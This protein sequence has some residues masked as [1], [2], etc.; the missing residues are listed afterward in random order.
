M[1]VDWIFYGLIILGL[2]TVPNEITF[3]A[4]PATKRA[5]WGLTIIMFLLSIV[6]LSATKTIWHQAISDSAGVS[7]SLKNPLDI[8]RTFVYV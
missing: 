6:V 1:F 8:G 2:A 3:N 4:K 5:A 7:I